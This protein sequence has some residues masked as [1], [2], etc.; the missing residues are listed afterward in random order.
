MGRRRLNVRLVSHNDIHLTY[1]KLLYLYAYT[2]VVV[3]GVGLQL[4][5]TIATMGTASHKT[6]LQ[7]AREGNPLIGS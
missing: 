6:I 1:P 4:W 3:V 5:A 7:A 2:V